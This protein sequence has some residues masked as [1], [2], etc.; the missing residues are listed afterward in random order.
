MNANVKV[1]F[2]LKNPVSCPVCSL[3]F[4][5]EEMLSGGGRLIARDITDELR[6][7]YEPSKKAGEVFPLV[8]PVNVCPGCLYAA[9]S[10]DF[11]VILQQQV[12][13]AYAQSIKRRRDVGMLFPVLDFNAP[14]NLFTGTASY[15][16]AISSY[17]FHKKE[18]APTFK[19]AISA[20][21]AAWLLGELHQR[22]P[23]QNYDQ[24]QLL[25]YR[26]AMRYY[27]LVVGYA[28]SGVERIDA[29]KHYGPDLDKNFGFE[30]VLFIASLLAFKYGDQGTREERISRLEKAK[31]TAS[32]VF[33]SGKSSRNK[34]SSIIDLSRDLFERINA[35]IEEIRKEG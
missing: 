34:P 32:R 26:K 14:R 33:G 15:L 35:R 19:K 17:S 10:E 2:F 1:S 6:R 8:Y 24:V 25:F 3:S 22:Y 13:A 16:L 21:R 28:Q 4:R 31:R 5:K 7:M 11:G 23:G 30:G 20:L 18:R 9:Y 27:D 12:D 29:V